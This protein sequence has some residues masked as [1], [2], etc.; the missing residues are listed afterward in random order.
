MS[1]IRQ[2]LEHKVDSYFAGLRS[3]FGNANT[4][5]FIVKFSLFLVQHIKTN[6]LESDFAEWG[7]QE[8]TRI[9][10]FYGIGC[11]CSPNYWLA[12]LT[13]CIGCKWICQYDDMLRSKYNFPHFRNNWPREHEISDLVAN[14]WKYLRLWDINNLCKMLDCGNRIFVISTTSAGGLTEITQGYDKFIV[15]TIT[16]NLERIK[17]TVYNMLKYENVENVLVEQN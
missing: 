16:A 9:Y 15:D 5:E 6:G 17:C 2:S 10:D 8:R 7:N 11:C 13:C 4:D 3:N 14:H 12:F 1:A